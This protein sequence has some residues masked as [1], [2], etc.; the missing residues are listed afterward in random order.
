MAAVV[1]PTG[2]Q[3]G[4]IAVSVM[5]SED[6]KNPKRL[7]DLED[8]EDSGDEKSSKDLVDT[9]HS[10][11]EHLQED[12]KKTEM[13]DTNNKLVEELGQLKKMNSAISSTIDSIRA[14]S[15]NI[16]KMMEN[17]SNANKMVD[18]WSQLILR[19]EQIT[20]MMSSEETRG[21]WRTPEQFGKDIEERKKRL[22]QLKEQYGKLKRRR[23][24][25][26]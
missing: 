9:I 1:R 3:A 18:I 26:W 14:I 25:V 5:C 17:T 2:D 20:K 23:K 24:R 15:G 11:S 7:K 13:E 22:T 16:D 21:V 10:D 6:L 8:L 4:E 12:D 19:D